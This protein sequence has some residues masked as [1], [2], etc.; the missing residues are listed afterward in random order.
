[1]IKFIY[2]FFIIFLLGCQHFQTLREDKPGTLTNLTLIGYQGWFNTPR[3][4]IGAGWQHWSRDSKKVTPQTV[5]F[6]L[7]P[8]VQDYPRSS[9]VPTGLG[10]LGN[11]TKSV[12][13]SSADK[14]VVKTHFKW[15][16]QYNLDGLVLQRF[17]S[18][19]SDAK[20]LKSANF[21]TSEIARQSALNNKHF[22]FM[23]DI[24]NSQADFINDIKADFTAHLENYTLSNP[25]YVKAFGKPVIGI[26]GFGFTHRPGTKEEAFEII[27]WF[28]Q[29]GYYV[30]GGVPFYWREGGRATKADWLDVFKSFDMLM[31]WS[32]GAIDSLAA[33]EKNY[34]D[35]VKKD[36][37]F[38]KQR[39]IGYQPVI[40]PGF[41][42]SNWKKGT[43]NFIPRLGGKFMWAQAEQAKILNLSAYIAMFDEYDESTAIAKAATDKSKIPRSKYFLTLDADGEKLSSDFYLKLTG[44]VTQLLRQDSKQ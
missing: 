7:Y 31:P 41:A 19:M 8:D 12:L 4:G 10:L 11:G 2:I 5:T 28:K 16:N 30:V 38:C 21:V 15:L 43:R 32:I 29:K 14:E 22:Y 17:I 24:S 9:L 20:R 23:Y 6:E 35:I 25:K 26:W 18:T 44:K 34:V 39:G 40:F 13:F 3:D 37:E 33:V 36:V 42:W 27:R 1:M